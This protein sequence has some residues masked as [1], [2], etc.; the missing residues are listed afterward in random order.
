MIE[1]RRDLWRFS[2]PTPLLQQRHLEP[3]AQMA[4][5]YLQGGRLHTSLGNLYQCLVTLTVKNFFLMPKLFPDV[6]EEPPV[7]QFM[8]I[9]CCPVTGH[10]WKLSG[11]SFLSSCLQVFAE[12]DEIPL[13]PF[14]LQAK[15]S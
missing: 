2:G 11:S 7:F 5:E 4:F 10:H 12:S 8:P 9:A 3:A 14:L 13:E 15:Q 1:V 6:Q